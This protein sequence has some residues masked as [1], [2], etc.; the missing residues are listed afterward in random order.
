MELT[1]ARGQLRSVEGAL[2]LA[3]EEAGRQVVEQAERAGIAE[4]RAAAL[5][6]RLKAVLEESAQNVSRL[7]GDV[8]GLQTQLNETESR[9][10]HLIGEAS[11]PR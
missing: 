6:G 3:S 7:S 2:Q 10:E 5:E 9:E 4:D 1:R 11:Q 8:Q